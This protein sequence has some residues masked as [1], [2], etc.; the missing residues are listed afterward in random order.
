M[1]CELFHGMP[2]SFTLYKLTQECKFTRWGY[3]AMGNQHTNEETQG[4]PTACCRQ[5]HN[6]MLSLN[7]ISIHMITLFKK[8]KKEYCK[9]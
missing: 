5:E 6:V 7:N 9:N 8:K 2:E 3:E 1:I 4:H